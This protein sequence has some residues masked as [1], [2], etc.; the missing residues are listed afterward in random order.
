MSIKI[1]FN[2]ALALALLAACGEVPTAEAPA[3]T[4]PSA[5]KAALTT[6]AAPARYVKYHVAARKKSGAWGPGITIWVN[7]SNPCDGF[8]KENGKYK[9]EQC[10]KSGETLVISGRGHIVTFHIT[11]VTSIEIEGE[12]KQDR[13][14]VA[15]PYTLKRVSG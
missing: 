13:D 15:V 14:T 2:A 12:R 10:V 11:D 3:P 8:Y 6:S 4:P 5:Q 9:L 7:P 1:F